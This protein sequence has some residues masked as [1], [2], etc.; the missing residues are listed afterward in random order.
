MQT[1]IEKLHSIHESLAAANLAHAFGGAIALA[2]CN[3]EPRGTRDID[4]NIFVDAEH[5]ERATSALPEGV[6][7]SSA[8][9]EVVRETGQTRLWWDGT[10]V[11]VFL[12]NIPFHDDVARG[13]RWVELAGSEIPV[14]DC[15]SLTIFK[16]LFDRPKD[17]V[18]I[19][20]IAERDPRVVAEAA[21]Q[22]QALTGDANDPGVIRLRATA[23][24]F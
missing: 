1:L 21:D 7:V 4:V 2:Y 19:A 18:D 9:L 5:A 14:L 22:L 3:K 15:K 20:T 23:S 11:D 8:D 16:A 17:W 6:A 24:E 13:V 12:N 10:P